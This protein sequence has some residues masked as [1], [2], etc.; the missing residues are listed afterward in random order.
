MVGKLVGIPYV[1]LNISTRVRIFLSH[2]LRTGEQCK[3][4]TTQEVLKDNRCGHIH[5]KIANDN[6]FEEAVS[7]DKL[8]IAWTQLKSSP[9]MLS[10]ADTQETFHKINLKWFETTN[11]ALLKGNFQYPNRRRF[12]V[13]KLI[14]TELRSLTISNP[15]IKIIEKALLNSIEPFFEGVWK[16]SEST[17][18]VVGN[19]R[20]KGFLHSNEYKRTKKGWFVK[21]WLIKPVFMPC[22][23]GSRPGRSPHSALKIIKEWSK[24]VVWLLDYGIKK[25]FDNVNKN[26]L[27][28]IFLKYLNQPRIWLEMEKM[29]NAGI[30]DINFVWEI[31]ELQ[32]NSI[33]ASFLFNVYMTELDR[34][35]TQ[36][37]SLKD[38]LFSKGHVF[39]LEAMREYKKL[40]VEFSNNRIHSALKKYGTVENVKSI[41]KNKMKEH[42]KKYGRRYGINTKTR[43]IFYTRYA[44]DFI[45]GIVGSKSFAMEVKNSV[46]T[47]LKSN[48]HLNVKKDMLIN[49]NSKG[50]KFL[51]YL[52]YL[53]TFNKKTRAIPNKLL[54]LTKYKR[55]VLARLQ[56]SDE[57][58]ARSTYYDIRRLLLAVYSKIFKSERLSLSK[59]NQN[60][61]VN[62]LALFS[63]DKMALKENPALDRWLKC[64]KD[65]SLDDLTLASKHMIDNIEGLKVPIEL[66][67][68]KLQKVKGLKEQ[69]ING[70]NLLMSDE[71]DGFFKKRREKILKAKEK[72]N[73]IK[74]QDKIAS[75]QAIQLA[76]LLTSF[77]LKKTNARNLSIMAPLKDIYEKLRDAGFSHPKI[78]RPCSNSTF[79]FFSDYEIFKVYSTVM[80]NLIY[81]YRVADNFSKVKSIVAHL[82]KSCLFTLARKHKKNKAWAYRT[83]GD[84]VEIII[85]GV[86]VKLP[87]R[88]YISQLGKKFLVDSP[89][90]N[91]DFFSIMQKYVYCLKTEKSYS[92]QCAVKNC[93]STDIKIR[94]LK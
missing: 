29:M 33:L 81:Y 32:Q 87:T 68:D 16:W 59:F 26:R 70:L 27:K 7:V 71:F 49:R 39:N 52:I 19:L 12:W 58:L 25:V 2:R 42:Y 41:I 56:K 8:L 51:G 73:I 79:I 54:S 65:R 18:E 34:F 21:N 38:C 63:R 45:L 84:D 69:F 44:D 74:S 43:R 66:G 94:K 46:N 28:N 24:N 37:S 31:K 75:K 36:L 50:T 89:L 30:I 13:S 22:N 62:L 85:K 86:S 20:Q 11:R 15:R 67:S 60:S 93:F 55:R 17:E 53:P 48:L 4:F 23:Q 35:V 72:T 80:Y 82:R 6:F 92:N 91:N 10:F 77:F 57:K 9:G 40:K 83:Y 88:N 3:T 64:F 90:L 47:F 1:H 76:N 14:R 78:N 61:V 5:R